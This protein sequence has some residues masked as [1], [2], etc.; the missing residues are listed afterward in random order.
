MSL[1]FSSFISKM[2]SSTQCFFPQNSFMKI[3]Y[4]DVLRAGD[5]I[6]FPQLPLFVSISNV[7]IGAK[8][9]KV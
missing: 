3:D 8:Q 1:S 6:L 9:K 2:V 5:M 4:L 7:Y